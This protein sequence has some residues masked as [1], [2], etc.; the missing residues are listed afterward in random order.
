MSDKLAGKRLKSIKND[1]QVQVDR[2]LMKTSRA[3]AK[4]H[5][6]AE[7]TREV[8]YYEK[9]FLESVNKARGRKKGKV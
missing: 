6:S 7:M 5:P 9:K 3:W 8:Q 1:L 2:N 4:M